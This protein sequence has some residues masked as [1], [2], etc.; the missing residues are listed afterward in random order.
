MTKYGDNLAK[1]EEERLTF[2]SEFLNT[3]E[4]RLIVG[5]LGKDEVKHFHAD[6]FL[7]ELSGGEENQVVVKLVG[8]E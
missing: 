8:R 4:G 5:D 3:E 1:E 6:G 7:Y 2:W